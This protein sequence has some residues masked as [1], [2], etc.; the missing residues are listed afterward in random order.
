[1]S[2]IL[3]WR[4]GVRILLA[5][6]NIVNQ[7]VALGI[8]KKLGL[9]ANAVTNGIGAV[10]ALETIPYDMVLMDC[11][12]PGMDG[13]TLCRKLREQKR[14]DTLCLILLTSK[15]E[16]EDILTGLEAGADEYISSLTI[17]QNCVPG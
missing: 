6:D 15:E 9:S 12:M 17:T 8:L 14:K 13:L 11:Q 5:E 2:L 1:M 3:R 7:K 16:R 10:K 4:S